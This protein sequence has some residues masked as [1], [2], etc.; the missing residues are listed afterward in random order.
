[1]V[2]LDEPLRAELVA[3][4]DDDQAAVSAVYSTAEDYRQA[5]ESSQ[6]NTSQAPWPFVLF[7]WAA[8]DQAPPEVRRA[9]QVVR[10]N[11]ARLKAVV[12]DHGWPGRSLVGE[13]G[14]HA[15]WLILQH[16]GRG[17]PLSER[18]T[19]TC[20]VGLAYGCWSRL[21]ARARPIRVIWRTSSTASGRALVNRRSMQ[22][23]PQLTPLWTASRSSRARWTSP[24]STGAAPKLASHRSAVTWTAEPETVGWGRLGRSG[25]T[26]ARIGSL[27]RGGGQGRESELV[28]PAERQTSGMS[29][30]TG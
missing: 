29:R 4:C 13:D 23:C 16:A 21:S 15:A 25:G 8:A 28:R 17:S 2:W 18:R 9:V 1:M 12:V 11:T 3:M 10:R 30:C 22:S 20:S 26:L 24:K 5:F 27:R 7:E 19:I 6:A 14:A